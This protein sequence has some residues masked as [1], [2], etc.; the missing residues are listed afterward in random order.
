M[1]GL[2]FTKRKIAIGGSVAVLAAGGVIGY[3]YFTSSGTGTGSGSTGS[4]TAATV[5]QATPA[6]PDYSTGDGHLYP[7]TTQTVHLTVTN[8]GKGF[9]KIATVKLTSVTSATAGCDSATNPGW[10]TMPTVAFG[11]AADNIGPGATTPIHDGVITFVDDGTPQD[12]C[13]GV[14]LTF[15]YTSA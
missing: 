3:A 5:N 9:Q 6:N 11:T 10:W 13:Q 12:V 2:S 4:S 7:S 8:N 15:H 14:A 1:K